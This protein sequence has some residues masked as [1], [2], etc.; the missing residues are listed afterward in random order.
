MNARS[1]CLR[2]LST[3]GCFGLVFGAIASPAW[4]LPGQRTETV[5]A[6]IAGNP[7][8]QPSDSGDGLTVRRTDTAAQRFEFRA[9]VLPPG[10]ISFLGNPG[11]I[12]SENF[13]LYDLINGVSL[14]RL[15]EAL[16]VIYGL[17]IYTD[18]QNAQIVRIYPSAD[19]LEMSRRLNLP[20]LG[21]R[22]GE[23]R[24]GIRFAYWIELT[25]NEDSS[26][27]SGQMTVFLKEDLPKM[28]RELG[29]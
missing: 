25:K 5:A 9:S 7:T 2:Y 3:L 17:D 14:P 19:T 16:R 12:R 29:Q 22:E 8:L 26:S 23:L 18:Y 6:W 24:L 1:F 20:G 15:E 13:S 27:H 11:I 10:R 21:G 4:S 28:L